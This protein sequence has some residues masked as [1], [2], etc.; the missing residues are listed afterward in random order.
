[1]IDVGIA[2]GDDGGGVEP[3]GEGEGVAD[4]V[5]R[6]CGRAQSVEPALAEMLGMTLYFECI[7]CSEATRQT[8]AHQAQRCRSGCLTP[9][10]SR[11]GIGDLSIIHLSPLLD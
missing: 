4:R 1:M 9:T 6:G 11:T 7:G 8:R 3:G 2:H 5:A 10:G